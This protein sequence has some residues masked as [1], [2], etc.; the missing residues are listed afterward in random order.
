MAID[1]CTVAGMTGTEFLEIWVIQAGVRSPRGPAGDW[2]LLL[3]QTMIQPPS[4]SSPRRRHARKFE[5]R[6]FTRTLASKLVRVVR[7][8]LTY[9]RDEPLNL[10]RAEALT[11][12]SLARHVIPQLEDF[13]IDARAAAAAAGSSPSSSPTQ[14][15]NSTSPPLAR[16]TS[17]SRSPSPSLQS[18]AAT[19]PLRVSLASS[20]PLPRSTNAT[21]STSASPTA[22]RSLY[23]TTT[24][25]V[26]SPLLRSSSSSMSAW[27]AVSSILNDPSTYAAASATSSS[28]S[29]APHSPSA[30]SSPSP[31]LSSSRSPPRSPH[32]QTTPA[33]AQ[34]TDDDTT[35]TEVLLQSPD[36]ATNHRLP[37]ASRSL[38]AS[39]RK[40]D[41]STGSNDDIVGTKRHRSYQ[42]PQR[43]KP[44]TT[45]AASSS[46]LQQQQHLSS[47]ARPLE[48]VTIV[49]S[50]IENPERGELRAKALDLG[51]QYQ[52][53][54]GCSLR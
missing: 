42:S 16:P 21:A 7:L 37:N 54:V 13:H 19:P 51:A 49:I 36:P 17:P 31:P 45:T 34:S 47:T 26:P 29:A 22:R 41:S 27:A 4:S 46:A 44:A 1:D 11:A 5:A 33:L 43:R 38:P 23:P 20:S 32:Y 25:D 50:G 30:T 10:T 28:A 24:T 12:Q 39:K 6:H 15:P 2:E 40:L 18:D 35:L 14:R 52:P 48:G 8:V 53:S 3:P 9:P